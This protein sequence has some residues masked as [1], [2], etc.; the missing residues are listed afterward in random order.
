MD[1][2]SPLVQKVRA[3]PSGTDLRSAAHRVVATLH[4]HEVEVLCRELILRHETD[5]GA[6]LAVDVIDLDAEDPQLMQARAVA[7]YLADRAVTRPR[8]PHG[9]AGLLP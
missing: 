2:F 1:V 8:P 9:P 5:A 6:A 4:P 3:D 7:R